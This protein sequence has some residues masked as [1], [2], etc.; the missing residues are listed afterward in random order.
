MPRC[1]YVPSRSPPYAEFG[2]AHYGLGFQ[3][4][5]YRGDWL[6]WHGGGWPGWNTQMT[7][8][9]DF[10]IGVAVFTNRSPNGVTSKR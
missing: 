2:D 10:G 9:P 8:V 6:V 7:L 3:C 4:I 1:V 5:G